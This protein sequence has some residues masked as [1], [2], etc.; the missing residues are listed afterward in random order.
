MLMLAALFLLMLMQP[1]QNA[2]NYATPEAA[3]TAYRQ[4][5]EKGDVEAFARLTT[6]AGGVTLR[7]LAPSLKKAQTASDALTKALADKPDFKLANPFADDLN[8]LKGYQFELIELTQGK[9]EHLARIRFGVANRLKEET[10]S[11]K[12]EAQTYRVSLPGVYLKSVTLLTPERLN[13]QIETLNAL[14]VILNNLA[15]QIN[16]GQLT[17]REA[18]LVKLAQA[19]RDAKLGD[20]K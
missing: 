16:K 17:T 18:V 6:G 19:V 12:K 20:S 2:A 8:P 5:V 10:V 13:K 15:E 9:D 4:A 11:V 3:L 14:T 7:T 1:A